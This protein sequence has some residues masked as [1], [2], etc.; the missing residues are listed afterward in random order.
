MK[1][2]KFKN[3]VS[4]VL[5]NRRSVVVTFPER[6]AVFDAST[7]EDRLAVTTCYPCPGPNPN[8]VALGSRW[9]V[10]ALSNTV[11]LKYRSWKLEWHSYWWI[12]CPLINFL[13]AKNN[14][15]CFRIIYL[16]FCYLT[17][18]VNSDLS[19]HVLEF[20]TEILWLSNSRN[21]EELWTVKNERGEVIVRFLIESLIWKGVNKKTLCSSFLIQ[22]SL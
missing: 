17:E 16:Q 12:F 22:C 14:I 18:K 1:S 9:Y 5:A 13:N 11:T 19:W 7:L 6:I 2:I 15:A 3:P 21:C 8:P 4:D 10:L 20:H